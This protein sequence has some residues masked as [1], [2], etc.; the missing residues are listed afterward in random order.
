[1]CCLVEEGEKWIDLKVV[2]ANCDAEII[3]GEAI[4]EKVSKAMNV[5]YADFR[6][7]SAKQPDVTKKHYASGS[8]VIKT[9][10]RPG[11]VRSWYNRKI[12]M[13]S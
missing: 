2:I 12:R 5:K 7:K 13:Q 4:L 10:P 1:V 3:E 11:E 9:T 8:V 6:P